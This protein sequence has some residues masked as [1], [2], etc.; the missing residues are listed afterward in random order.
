MLNLRG[1]GSSSRVEWSNNKT[2]PA[3]TAMV[4]G[5]AWP[6]KAIR[7]FVEQITLESDWMGTMS[8]Q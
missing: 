5:Q 1:Y 7:T 4:M 6:I 8:I 3:H 2:Q